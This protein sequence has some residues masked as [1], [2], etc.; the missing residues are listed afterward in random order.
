M[1]TNKKQSTEAA[2]REISRPPIHRSFSTGALVVSCACIS[3]AAGG[4]GA[5]TLDDRLITYRELVEQVVGARPMS[6]TDSAEDVGLPRRRVRR[7]DVADRR[8]NGFDFLAIQGCALSEHIGARNNPTGLTMVPSRRLLYEL[9]VLED[10][11]ACIAGLSDGRADKI[12]RIIQEKQRERSVHVWNAVW[13]GEEMEAY[14]AGALPPFGRATDRA[15]PLGAAEMLAVLR[16][17]VRLPSDAVALEEA[18]AGLRGAYPN[19]AMLR[20]LQKAAWELAE[21]AALLESQPP[22]SRCS[23]DSE[24]LANVFRAQFVALQ[25]DLAR[26]GRDAATRLETLAL[27]FDAT[28]ES[29]ARVPPAMQQYR[30][31]MLDPDSPEALLP[32]YVRAV[33]RHA[34]AW[35]PIADRCGLVPTASPG[36]A[37]LPDSRGS[38]PL[39]SLSLSAN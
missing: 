30:R 9:E 20:S 29:L 34:F 18:L 27:V 32:R 33:K 31:R 13:L 1:A 8:I 10:A 35:Q 2:V 21:V 7:I 25:P 28:T 24:R 5:P 37:E 23:G 14:L 17:P 3:F 19:G 26:L 4:C 11:A 39:H 15:E 16:R 38:V 12:Q 22:A 6:S 36:S